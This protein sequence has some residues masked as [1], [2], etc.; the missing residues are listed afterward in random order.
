[1]ENPELGRLAMQLVV[2][3][4]SLMRASEQLNERGSDKIVESNIQVL[5]ATLEMGQNAFVLPL[6]VSVQLFKSL[7]KIVQNCKDFIRI[8]VCLLINMMLDNQK[9]DGT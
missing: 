1:M 2:S 3:V 8:K 7:V 6:G 9:S 5:I 4:K